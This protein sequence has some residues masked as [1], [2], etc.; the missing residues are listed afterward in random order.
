MGFINFLSDDRIFLSI[1]FSL[2]LGYLEISKE[3]I[4]SFPPETK[5]ICF[6]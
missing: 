1:K 5:L 4:S 3:T 6:T 2:I